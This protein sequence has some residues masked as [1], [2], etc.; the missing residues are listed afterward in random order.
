MIM[1]MLTQKATEVCKF[2]A[3]NQ[4]TIATAESCTGG[5]IAELLTSVSGASG[6]FGYGFVT[7][8]NEAKEKLLGVKKETLSQFGAVS[9]QTVTEM[10]EGALKAANAD[11]AVSVSGIA[12]PSGGT[13]EKPVGLVYVGL[14]QKGK[15]T[16]AIKN[17]FDGS[18][19]SVRRQ[20]A[21]KVFDLIL[22]IR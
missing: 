3:D 20:T 2:L 9:S 16:R 13:K 22:N 10:A 21:E 18:R 6:V 14:S 7:Y 12:G 15:D 8:S 5:M 1:D 17:N 19:D 4:M 11:I